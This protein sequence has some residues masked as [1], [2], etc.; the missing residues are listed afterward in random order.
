MNIDVKITYN[1]LRDALKKALISDSTR[2][3]RKARGVFGTREKPVRNPDETKVEVLALETAAAIE[4]AKTR[5]ATIPEVSYPESLPVSQH[6]EEIAE[7]IRKHQVVK[8][9]EMVS[10]I[11]KRDKLDP[12]SDLTIGMEG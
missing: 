7:L 9:P 11:I 2:I 6:H 5:A 3:L 4:R 12:D 1:S 10:E 8:P